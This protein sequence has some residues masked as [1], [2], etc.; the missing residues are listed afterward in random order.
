MGGEINAYDDDLAKLYAA[1]IRSVI[2]LLNIPSD[3]RVYSPAGFDFLCCPIPNGDIPSDE[4]V[5]DILAFAE[6]ASSPIAVH[7]EAGIGRTGTILALLLMNDGHEA[8]DAIR[9]VRQAQPLA[10]ETRKQEEFLAAWQPN[11]TLDG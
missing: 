1:G 10:V 6:N 9:L 3:K 11:Q 4:Q 8:A 5:D 7:C 2:C